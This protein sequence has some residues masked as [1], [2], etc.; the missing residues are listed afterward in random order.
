MELI[1]KKKKK[2]KSDVILKNTDVV[3]KQKIGFTFLNL[4]KKV[5]A[6]LKKRDFN[7][8]MLSLF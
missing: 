1:E 7:P 6:G 2:P 8:R 3:R 4:K 5:F